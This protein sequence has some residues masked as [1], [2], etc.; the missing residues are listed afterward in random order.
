MFL[1]KLMHNPH[2]MTGDFSSLEDDDNL[3]CF[4]CVIRPS[5]SLEAVDN[6]VLCTLT[7]RLPNGYPLTE[8]PKIE[9]TSV[10][11]LKMNEVFRHNVCCAVIHV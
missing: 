3:S 5:A 2:C 11:G 10:V 8:L 4:S 6:K 1:L 7:M 9:I